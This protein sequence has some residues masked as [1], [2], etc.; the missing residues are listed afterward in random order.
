MHKLLPYF[1]CFQFQDQTPSPPYPTFSLL[2]ATVRSQLRAP[3]GN[4]TERTL[5][6][7]GTTNSSMYVHSTVIGTTYVDFKEPSL[8]P[9][10]TEHELYGTAHSLLGINPLANVNIFISAIASLLFQ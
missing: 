7:K 2:K 1:Q 3:G 6:Y 8:F 10:R 9:S 5:I 4:Q